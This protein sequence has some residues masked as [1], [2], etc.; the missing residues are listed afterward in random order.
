MAI[1]KCSNDLETHWKICMDQKPVSTHFQ[2]KSTRKALLNAKT[3]FK[4]GQFLNNKK[5]AKCSKRDLR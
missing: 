2:R 4:M 5:S 1:W 3:A